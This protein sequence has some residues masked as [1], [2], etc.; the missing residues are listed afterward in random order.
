MAT[1]AKRITQLDEIHAATA[2]DFVVIV[3]D[4]AGTPSTRKMTVKNLFGNSS[5]NVAIT[6]I[7]PSN[8]TITAV[9]AGSLFYDANYLYV[10]VSNNLI[11]R[12]SLS[13]F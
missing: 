11:K 7:S 2:D 13:F 12:V 10:A 1:E 4:P 6:S 5:A 3:N 9:K 8:S